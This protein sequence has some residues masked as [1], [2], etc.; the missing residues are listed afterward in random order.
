M[1]EAFGKPRSNSRDS[2]R[3]V[4]VSTKFLTADPFEK[5]KGTLRGALFSCRRTVFQGRT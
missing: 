5:E 2:I 3:R 4:P 1:R